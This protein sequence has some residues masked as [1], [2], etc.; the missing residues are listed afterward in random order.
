MKRDYRHIQTLED[1]HAEQLK[2]KAICESQERQLKADASYYVK[3][4]TPGG[5]IKKLLNR[6][7][8]EKVDGALNLSGKVMSLV[9]PFFLNKTVFK[10]SGFLTRAIVGLISNKVGGKMDLDNITGIVDKL[11]SWIMPKGKSKPKEVDY[12]IPP[13]SETY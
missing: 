11:K 2:L 3:Q 6:G 7:N 4:F 1:L 12:G 13:Y 10:G 8:I 9:L 5:F